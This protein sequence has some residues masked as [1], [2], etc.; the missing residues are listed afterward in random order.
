MN[1]IYE[2]MGYK[3]YPDDIVMPKTQ[4][5]T[6]YAFPEE[7]N[8]PQIQQ[9]NNW[10]NLDVFNKNPEQKHIELEELVPKKFLDDN[11]NGKFSGKWIYVSLGSMGSVDLNLMDRLLK[12]LNK[13]N[14][15]YIV[16][17]G[18]RHYEF[19]LSGNLWG[20]RYLP[21]QEILPIVDLVITHGG[22]NTVTETF[23]QGKPM[24][25]LPLFADQ[26]DNGQR[27]HETKW[28]IK[29]NP[30][31]FTEEQM[32]ESIDQL[33]NDNELKM[34]LDKA[35]KRIRTSN[36]QEIL[37]QLIDKIL[38]QSEVDNKIKVN[39]IINGIH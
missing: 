31:S 24:I 1:D 32:I 23:A 7:Y 27:L 35:S 11:L 10:F 16:S 33:L 2:T 17:K 15:K 6:I 25:I 18:P 37:C 14:H 4:K 34:K 26:H 29:L 19:E 38:E 39:N 20:E 36:K 5:L 8:Y 3:R 21:Q 13:T 22:N 30:Y 28:A 9:L 12:T